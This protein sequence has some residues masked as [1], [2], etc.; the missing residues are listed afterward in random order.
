MIRKGLMA[1]AVAGVLFAALPSAASAQDAREAQMIGFHT[2]CQQGDRRACIHF[3]MMLQQ[4]H[5]RAAEWR[6][7]HPEWF[8]WEH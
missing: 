6:H 7:T 1:A 5:D 4:N 8:W 2:L 3:G